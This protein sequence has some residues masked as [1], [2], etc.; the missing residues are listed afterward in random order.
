MCPPET[1]ELSD[2]IA[3]SSPE[4]S[5]LQL[6]CHDCHTK[7]TQRNLQPIEPGSQAD[8]TWSELRCPS[9]SRSCLRVDII[10][11]LLFD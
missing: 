11:T 6:L 9:E 1:I 3:N 8:K 2:H 4:L 10:R 5:N 7:K